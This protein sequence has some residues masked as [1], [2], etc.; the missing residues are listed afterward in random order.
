MI[1]NMNFLF[2]PYFENIITYYSPCKVLVEIRTGS[3]IILTVN[4]EFGLPPLLTSK[5]TGT[6]WAE[7]AQRGSDVEVSTLTGYFLMHS[8][9]CE[10]S[11]DPF[12]R[13]WAAVCV[14]GA[15]LLEITAKEAS[16]NRKFPFTVHRRVG[17]FILSG[18]ASFAC[19]VRTS[20]RLDTK[21]F[22]LCILRLN[23][24]LKYFMR[25]VQGKYLKPGSV[26]AIRK[27]NIS[28]HIWAGSSNG[29]RIF[30]CRLC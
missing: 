15:L 19:T 13:F 14:V 8:E 24:L 10:G 6:S 22:A 12:L 20:I 11:L 28:N 4:F 26:P 16:M 5:M 9:R 2:H 7:L 23:V 17:T 21:L 25:N 3:P 1:K 18:K 30:I 29:G 27:K